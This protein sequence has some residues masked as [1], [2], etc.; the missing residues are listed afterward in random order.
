MTTK[1]E[2]LD[3]LDRIE[4]DIGVLIAEA[5]GPTVAEAGVEPLAVYQSRINYA[6]GGLWLRHWIEGKEN[7]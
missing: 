7:A 4:K 1:A 5:V 6:Q 3:V 2:L